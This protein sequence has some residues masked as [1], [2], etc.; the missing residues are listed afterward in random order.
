MSSR[1]KEVFDQ[2]C[3][4][5]E[6]YANHHWL[7]GI[8]NTNIGSEFQ[9]MS[10]KSFQFHKDVIKNT[11]LR[12]SSFTVLLHFSRKW[13]CH[14]EAYLVEEMWMVWKQMILDPLDYEGFI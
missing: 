11:Y 8:N 2:G 1:K 10:L 12:N 6:K 13:F 7:K 3:H 4:I 9:K 14:S 5:C